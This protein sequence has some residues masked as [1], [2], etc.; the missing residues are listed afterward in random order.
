MQAF[1]EQ[2]NEF[3]FSQAITENHVKDVSQHFD[4]KV[5]RR[6]KQL[7]IERYYSEKGE[8]KRSLHIVQLFVYFIFIYVFS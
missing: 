2:E 8:G 1:R 3:S 6:L 7:E 4:P 5:H